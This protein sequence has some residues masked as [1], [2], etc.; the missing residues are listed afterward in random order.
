MTTDQTRDGGERTTLQFRTPSPDDKVPKSVSNLRPTD[1][2]LE[3]TATLSKPEFGLGMIWQSHDQVDLKRIRQSGQI[4]L[5]RR[6]QSRVSFTAFPQVAGC[7]AERRDQMIIFGLFNVKERQ[8]LLAIMGLAIIAALIETLGVASAIPF[9]AALGDPSQIQT[10]PYLN[11][12]Y[13]FF[14]STSAEKYLFFLGI[15]SF[16][17]VSFSSIFR[18][19]SSYVMNNFIELRRHSI[20]ERLLHIYLNEKYEFFIENSTSNLSKQMLSEVD[21]IIQGGVRPFIQ[22]IAYSFVAI[23]LMLFLIFFNSKIAISVGLVIGGSYFLVF[24]CVKRLLA[25]IGNARL[26]SNQKRFHAAAEAFGAIKDIKLLGSEQ[27][28]LLQFQGPSRQNAAYQ[29]LNTTLTQLPKFFIE[30]IGFGTIIVLALVLLKQSENISNNPFGEILPILGV[31][32]FAGL[33]LLPAAQNIYTG[34]AN[35]KFSAA[36]IADLC[37]VLQ[38]DPEMNQKRVAAP[39]PIKLQQS[40][41]LRGVSYSYPQSHNLALNEI[42]FRMEA[43]TKFGIVGTTGG[44]KTTL[45]D[46]ILGLLA[47]TG[48]EISVD[49]VRIT[50]EN[51]A[52]WQAGIGYVR[53]DI[54]LADTSVAANIAFGV[55]PEAIDMAQV[56]QC[57]RIANIHDFIVEHMPQGY[58]TSVGERGIRLSGGQRQRLGIARA[59]YRSPGLIVLDE[60]TS[61]LDNKTEMEIMGAIYGL[62]SQMTA[63]L[64]A[65]RLSTIRKCDHIIMLE[66]GTIVAQGTYDDLLEKSESFRQLATSSVP[67]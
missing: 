12:G 24:I 29:A 57:A 20:S 39:L 25:R 61:A 46:I 28:H 34:I 17:S 2:P 56:E 58:D 41:Q 63:I 7:L 49:G 23:I 55:A 59:L 40:L 42:S 4:H 67:A 36:A 52:A 38:K 26:A 62:G 3:P 33:R 8:W 43:G 5:T 15:L 27:H 19:F 48:G 30:A 54:F 35:L 66:R 9:L 50:S 16:L 21:Q 47:P 44:G 65:H 18:I 10:N 13:K 1:T 51:S 31:Y 22:L 64:I 32:A 11:A 45:V 6:S 53:Q 37:E 60:A 14:G